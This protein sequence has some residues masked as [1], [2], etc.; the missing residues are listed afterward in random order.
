LS[1][2]KEPP[3]SDA[4]LLRQ[5]LEGVTPLPPSNRAAPA[6]SKPPARVAARAATSPAPADTLSDHGAG[7]IPLTDYMR[8][9]VSRMTLRKL[10]RGY[11]PVQDTLDLHGLTTDGARGLLAAFLHEAAQQGLR[12][13]AVIHGKGIHGNDHPGNRGAG[14][15]KALARHWLTQR[16]DVLAFCEAP[17]NMGG[18]GAV[19]VLLKAH[20]AGEPP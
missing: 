10:K 12:C 3:A 8:N 16:A 17:Q 4:D 15:L 14:V 1:G 18:G 20:D 13:V 9:G 2:E 11:F 5:A 19:W 6:K 7:E